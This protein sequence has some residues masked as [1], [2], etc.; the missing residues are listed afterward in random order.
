M[1]DT[2]STPHTPLHPEADEEVDIDHIKELSDEEMLDLELNPDLEEDEKCLNDETKVA[3]GKKGEKRYLDD[4]IEGF[5]DDSDYFEPRIDLQSPFNSADK[6]SGIQYNDSIHPRRLSASQQSKFICFCDAKLM[7]IQR[8]VVQNRGLNTSA[9]YANL[10]DLT[11]D[12]KRLVDF[13]WFSID[14]C[15]NT[16]VLFMEKPEHTKKDYTGTQSTNFGQTHYLI[17]IA[18]DFLDYLDKFSLEE[19]DSNTRSSI[20]S[21]VFKFLMIMDKIFARIID[22]RVPGQVKLSVTDRVRVMGIAERTRYIIPNILET[23]NISGYHYEL[24]KIYDETL[25]RCG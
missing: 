21:R 25:D 18:D 13:I 23:Q 15:A 2:V 3:N 9:G 24:S 17:R 1:S 14:G 8:K 19:L 5:Y 11:L 4:A 20:L 10:L 7:N 16:E 6:L 12:L 22:G